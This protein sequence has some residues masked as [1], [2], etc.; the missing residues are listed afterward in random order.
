MRTKVLTTNLFYGDRSIAPEIGSLE[1]DPI[2]GGRS[3][4]FLIVGCMT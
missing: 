2:V 3:H 1:F 4:I